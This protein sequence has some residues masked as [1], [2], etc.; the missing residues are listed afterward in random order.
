MRVT[1]SQRGTYLIFRS[2]F[3]VALL[4]TVI[5]IAFYLQDIVRAIVFIRLILYPPSPTNPPIDYV[6]PEG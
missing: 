2:F 1:E 4:I 6:V 5:L 3:R